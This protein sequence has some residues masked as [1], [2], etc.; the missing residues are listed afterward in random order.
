MTCRAN[1]RSRSVTAAGRSWH[2]ALGACLDQLEPLPAGVN[3]GVVYFAEPLAPMADDIVRALRER[4]G[5]RQWLG[6][7]G[8]GVLGGP[9]GVCDNGLAV[10]VV[11]LP[12]G[13]FRVLPSAPAPP[14]SRTRTPRP[15]WRSWKGTAPGWWWAGSPPPAAPPCRSR[16]P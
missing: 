8:G 4:T 1:L 14:R 2:G 12:D 10:L 13:G 3:F 5:V 15:C 6:A 7:C 16:A 9:S 11:E